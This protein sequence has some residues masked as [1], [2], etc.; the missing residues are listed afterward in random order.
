MSTETL[1]FPAIEEPRTELATTE[2]GAVDLAKIDLQAVAL[3][4]FNSAH[5]DAKKAAET[6]TGVVHDLSTSTKLAEAKSLRNRLINVPLADAR[7]VSSGLKS[8]LTAVSRA[9]GAE[10]EAIEKEFEKAATLITPQIEAREAEIAEEKRI[11]AE[12]EAAR[13]EAHMANLAKLAEPAER[14]RQPGMTTE[15]I[16]NGIKAV[17]AIAI[18]RT[19]WEEFADRAEE[20]KAVTL[21]RMRALLATAQADEERERVAAAQRAEA[22]RLAAM[23]DE[24]ARQRAELEAKQ[25]EAIAAAKA[26]EA[27]RLEREQREEAERQAHELAEAAKRAEAAEAQATNSPE[28][29][30]Q[31]VLKVE[32]TSPPDTT[33]RDGAAASPSVGSMG[34][35]QAADAAPTSGGSRAV[36]ELPTMTLGQI[37]ARLGFTV[38]ADFLASLGF[39]AHKDKSARLYR[40]SQFGAICDRI[41]GHVLRAASEKQAA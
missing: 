9:V 7:K 15:R 30:V 18:D 8:K 23:A 17:E 41:S 10:L 38:T 5:A 3:A 2:P 14:C 37:N 6:L 11:A 1:E 36:S 20:Q 27:A 25:A 4:Q 29:T 16:A 28:Q 35:G 39:E 12:Q 40:P 19:A 34:A 31:H 24:L 33:D 26:E 13:V 22:E 32:A 21:E